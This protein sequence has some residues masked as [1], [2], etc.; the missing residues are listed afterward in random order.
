VR[1]RSGQQVLKND[2]RPVGGDPKRGE[3]ALAQRF[4]LAKPVQRCEVT[5]RK[6]YIEPR[7]SAF[8]GLSLH[9]SKSGD[10]SPHSK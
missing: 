2:R 4:A 9:L 1:V 8:C 6:R 10:R 5:V 7:A 3:P